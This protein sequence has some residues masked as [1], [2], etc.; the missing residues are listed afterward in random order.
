MSRTV[1]GL[2]DR[3]YIQKAAN[4]EDGRSILLRLSAEGLALS[5]KVL[6][7][8]FERNEQML[9]TLSS[10]ERQMLVELM[11]RVIRTSSAYFH[12]LKQ[13]ASQSDLEQL[14]EE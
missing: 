8:S 6:D 5:E 11:R 3:G 4:P 1:S 10:A 14:D 13:Q 7:D 9:A 12:D 2:I